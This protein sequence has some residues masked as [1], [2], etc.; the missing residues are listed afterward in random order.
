MGRGSQLLL[1]PRL[2]WARQGCR[3][4]WDVLHPQEPGLE[5]SALSWGVYTANNHVLSLLLS[6]AHRAGTTQRGLSKNAAGSELGWVRALGLFQLLLC[7]WVSFPW[8]LTGLCFPGDSIC[9]CL[10]KIHTGIPGCSSAAGCWEG[11]FSWNYGVDKVG[12]AL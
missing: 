10:C 6:A 12:K 4:G 5:I 1:H 7:P 3:E 11:R 8:V 9:S 2:L